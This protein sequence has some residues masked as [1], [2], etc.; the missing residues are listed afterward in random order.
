MTLKEQLKAKQAE[1][2]A[3]KDAIENGDVEAIAKAG[4]IADAISLL[5]RS[6]NDAA[7]ANDILKAMG[8]P[9]S[10]EVAD[11]LKS[12]KSGMKSLIAQAKSVD[13]KQ[14][15][16]SIAA[17]FKDASNTDTITSVQIADVDREVVVKETQ[18]ARVADLLPQARISGNAVTY[19]VETGWLNPSG[20][21]APGIVSEG[22]K[23]PQGSDSFDPET[24]A[25]VKIAGF[26]KETDEVLD[27]NDFLASAVEE[28][29]RRKLIKAENAYVVGKITS[30]ASSNTVEYAETSGD[31]NATTQAMMEAIL[32][33]KSQ[34]EE[35]TDYTADLILMNSADAFAMAIAKDSNG[36]YYGGGW[37]SG[38]YGNGSYN[39]S[40]TPW[41]MRIF[42]SSAITAGEPYVISTEALKFYRKNDTAVRVYE[43]NEDDAL[44]N[45]VTILAEE[46]VLA[47]VKNA[48]AVVPVAPEE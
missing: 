36:Q 43:Q 18:A 25:L 22:A 37:A 19:F 39:A 35:N 23:K 42:T 46:R 5:E 47:V 34:I 26:A 7:R 20:G 11:D 31:T 4:E 30:G 45:R 24:E 32:Q 15:G 6:I 40:V 44:Y 17:N 28:V 9:D 10:E 12:A 48:E 3:L 27:D 21:T 33:A 38:A 8:T 2:V 13:K 16:W 29:L 41:G 14:K 1:L